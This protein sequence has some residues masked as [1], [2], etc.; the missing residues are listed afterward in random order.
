VTS[1]RS[2]EN[3]LREYL[4]AGVHDDYRA[5]VNC[6]ARDFENIRVNLDGSVTRLS[7]QTMVNNLTALWN[8][9]GRL[10]PADDVVVLAT[11]QFGQFGSVLFHRLKDGHHFV[12]T[13]TFDLSTPT[14]NLV[15]EITVETQ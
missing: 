4:Q 12:Y 15:Q 5:L 8:S 9:G 10:Q 1:T 14:I 6:Y 3:R 11:T 13:F 7:R 2:A